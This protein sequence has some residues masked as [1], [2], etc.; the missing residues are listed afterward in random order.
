MKANTALAFILS[1][2]AL[3][4]KQAPGSPTERAA[5]S[6]CAFLALLIGLVSFVEHLT[7]Y[8]FGVDQ[9]LVRDSS[10]AAPEHPGRMAPATASGFILLG[11]A[12]LW[13][14]LD[15]A[16]GRRPGE[17]LALI[18]A[19][20]ALIALAG[21]AYDVEALYRIDDAYSSV[22]LHTALIFVVLSLGV[23]WARPD[24]GLMARVGEFRFRLAPQVITLVVLAVF[25][26]RWHFERGHGAPESKYSTRT[27]HRQQSRIGRTGRGI[28][29][30]LHRG[31]TDE[32]P[33]FLLGAPSSNNRL[34]AAISA[35]PRPSFRSFCSSTHE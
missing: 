6:A 20:F 17:G 5:G 2:I 4:L 33:D 21:Y 8:D 24:R 7:G 27:D 22:A 35:P 1:G 10:T 31:H 9:L 18:T 30:P 13:L 28:R 16:R 26:G 19:S 29:A 34:L 25:F 15:T 32:R 12:L 3:W 14:D 11:A 23:L